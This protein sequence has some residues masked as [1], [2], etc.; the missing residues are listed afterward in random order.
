MHR[1]VRRQVLLHARQPRHRQRLRPKTAWASKKPSPSASNR[2]SSSSPT[3]GATSIH[4]YPDA[5]ADCTR[6]ASPKKQNT[7]SPRRH[8]RTNKRPQAA[9]GATRAPRLGDTLDGHFEPLPEMTRA[10]AVVSVGAM[11]EISG[12]IYALDIWMPPSGDRD[13]ATDE[14]LEVR[15]YCGHDLVVGHRRNRIDFPHVAYKGQPHQ[16]G[17][18]QSGTNRSL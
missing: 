15:C 17:R 16:L 12:P 6:A 1:D 10:I 8:D 7:V 18:D 2:K 5:G 13:V 4:R 14:L 11:R 3:A 9:V